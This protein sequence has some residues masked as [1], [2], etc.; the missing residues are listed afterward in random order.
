[1]K[2]FKLQVLL[3]TL[4]FLSF[5]V[6]AQDKST[7]K[8][9]IFD[10][11]CPENFMNLTESEPGNLFVGFNSKKDIYIYAFSPDKELNK[12][13]LIKKTLEGAF[14]K[15][16][17]NSYGDYKVKDSDDFWGTSTWSKYE[18]E[19]YAKAGFNSQNNHVVHF[20]YVLL[21][22]KE[23]QIVVGFLYEREKGENAKQEF[24]EWVGGGN[25]GA[26]SSLGNLIVSITGEKRDGVIPGGPP[27]PPPPKK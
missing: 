3:L 6:N 14:S 12:E 7:C 22:F 9:G 27:P 18:K 13:D 11:A 15:V 20:Q 4:L 17:Y 5:Q 25:G 1:M 26:S 24:D 21:S 2:F 10:F 19:K 8:V 16:F 23:K